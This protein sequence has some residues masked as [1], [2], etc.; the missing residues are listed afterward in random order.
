ML[1]SMKRRTLGKTGAQVSVLGIGDVADRSAPLE[2]CVSD[3]AAR[4]RLRLKSGGHGTGLRKR[5]QRTN[6]RHRAKWPARRHVRH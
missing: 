2:T 4:D 1:Q 6:R 5:L 3:V